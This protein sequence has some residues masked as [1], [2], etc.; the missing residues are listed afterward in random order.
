MRP[1]AAMTTRERP[2]DRGRR[3]ARENRAR[4]AA[5]MRRARVA[6]GLSLRRIA[7]AAGLDHAQ[8]SRFERGEHELRLEDVGAI[9]AIVGLDVAIRTYPAGDAIRDVAHARLLDR[10]RREL[11]PTLRWHTEVPF[12]EPGDLRAWDAL[13]GAR[14]W[15]LGIEAETV[16][17]DTQALDRKLQIKHRDGLVDHVLLLV[18]D[19]P[20]NRRNL[21]A[22]PAAFGEFSRDSRQ[23]L[24]AL[25]A[26]EDPGASG[27]VIL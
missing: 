7:E 23:L 11:H 26:G 4:L 2:A 8:I 6:A 19:T 22:A 24:R 21:A 10:L 12:P 14:D 9:A 5:D 20:R 1:Y 17:A 18:A 15:R 25:R 16:V 27:I 3:R 13:T